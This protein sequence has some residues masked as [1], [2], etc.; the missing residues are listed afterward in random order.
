MLDNFLPLRIFGLEFEVLTIA[1][2]I[3]GQYTSLGY[4]LF[5]VIKYRGTFVLFFIK[6]RQITSD[7]YY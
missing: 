4:Y 6:A 1:W 2:V 7:M 3:C 5:I